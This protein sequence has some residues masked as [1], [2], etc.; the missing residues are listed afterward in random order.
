LKSTQERL[1]EF[2]EHPFF[3]KKSLGQNFLVSDHVVDKILS[4]V[5][6][7]KPAEIIEIGP[8][9][10][11]LT[12][13][14]VSWGLP[15]TALE[16]DGRLVEY[17]Q[18]R[19][20]NVVSTDALQWDWAQHIKKFFDDSKALNKDSSRIVLVSNL[21]YQISSRIVV[22]RSLDQPQL[23]AMVLMFQKEVAQR[24]RATPK[25]DDYG[26]LSMVAQ[27]FWTISTVC[28]AGPRD[29]NPPPRVASRVLSFVQKDS[30]IQDRQ[31]YFEFLKQ[32][33]SQRRKL[34]KK[35][36]ASGEFLNLDQRAILESWLEKNKTVQARVEELSLAQIESLYFELGFK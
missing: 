27:S 9:P 32:A 31:K 17:W 34:L 7:N 1:K 29:F 11:A 15:Y 5:Q 8:G 24:I 13:H 30:A 2:L 21:P 22:D 3:T 18:G 12:D 35:N 26:F 4:E 16:L 28:E 36:L 6:K 10:G 25:S 20:V 14:L 19:Q 23:S 33:W